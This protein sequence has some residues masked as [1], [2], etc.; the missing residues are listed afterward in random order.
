[1]PFRNLIRNGIY[2]CDDDSKGLTSARCIPADEVKPSA[3][4]FLSLCGI[5]C[6]S[7]CLIKSL[8]KN[9]LPSVILT[10][11]TA[12]STA[13]IAEA[14]IVILIFLYLT[15]NILFKDLLSEYTKELKPYFLLYWRYYEKKI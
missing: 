13:F 2:S 4:F 1:M 15:C 12:P 11:K 9:A 7:S 8:P 14:V 6:N 10:D 5:K 3:I